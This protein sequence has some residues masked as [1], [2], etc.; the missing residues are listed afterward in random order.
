VWETIIIQAAGGGKP[1]RRK[2]GGERTVSRC[3]GITDEKNKN[4]Y[5]N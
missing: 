3:V 4:K 1:N 5:M 2:M